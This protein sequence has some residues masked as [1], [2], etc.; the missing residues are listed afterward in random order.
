MTSYVDALNAALAA[1]HA[2]LFVYGALGA[3]TSQTAEPTLYAA[4]DSAYAE[5]RARRDQLVSA[6]LDEGAAPTAAE[7]AYAL[8]ADLSTP[9]LVMQRRPPARAVVRRDL[10]LPGGQQPSGA[11]AVGHQRTDNDSGPRTRFPGNS[12]DI[13]RRERVRGP[14]RPGTEALTA[15]GVGSVGCLCKIMQGEPIRTRSL[16]FLTYLQCRNLQPA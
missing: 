8:P 6:I 4:I 11:A 2:A 9:D 3:Q 10:R 14:L 7:P 13:P 1:E 16:A 15:A 12:R 5:H